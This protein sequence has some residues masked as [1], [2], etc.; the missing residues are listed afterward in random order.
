[1]FAKLSRACVGSVA[2]RGGPGAE[3][4]PCADDVPM[5]GSDKKERT[6]ANLGICCPSSIILKEGIQEDGGDD[7]DGGYDEGTT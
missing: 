3:F 2:G 1:M 5:P 7:D 4:H 6:I